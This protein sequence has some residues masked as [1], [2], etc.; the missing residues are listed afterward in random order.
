MTD[1]KKRKSLNYLIRKFINHLMISGKKE[2][3][4]KIFLNSLY[5][6]QQ[7]EKQNPLEIFLK[8]LE[9]LTQYN[10]IFFSNELLHLYKQD[11]L[12][13]LS[14]TLDFPISVS[15]EKLEEILSLNSNE[16]YLKPADKSLW[17]DEYMQKEAWK[18]GNPE[19]PNVYRPKK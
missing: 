13:Q 15:D 4:E 2:K 12:K 8:A 7:R 5:F 3:A 10:P 9:N 18:N 11:Y 19:N 14:K 6:L 1:L 16:K 17:V